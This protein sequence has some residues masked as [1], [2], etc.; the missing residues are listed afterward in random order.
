VHL[1]YFTAV[2]DERGG[3]RT[4]ADIYGLDGPMAQALFG[5]AAAS[6]PAPPQPPAAVAVQNQRQ[7]PSRRA[8]GEPIAAFG[9]AISGLFGN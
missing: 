5:Q 8:S 3:V 1:T 2:A 9:S 4:Y 7:Q 6:F